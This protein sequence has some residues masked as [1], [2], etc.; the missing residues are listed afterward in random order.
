MS[1]VNRVGHSA[2][3]QPPTQM[4]PLVLAGG[5]CNIPTNSPSQPTFCWN[6]AQRSLGKVPKTP[7][8]GEGFALHFL[9][10]DGYIR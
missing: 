10:G 6:F 5:L 7:N 4:K 2:G 8:P 9:G 1:P 3:G